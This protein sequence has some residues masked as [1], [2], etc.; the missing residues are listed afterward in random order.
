MKK[1]LL[2]VS[3]LFLGI[4]LTSCD[5]FSPAETTT[6]TEELTADTE[7][8]IEISTASELEAIDM[9]KSY[10]LMADLNLLGIEW[11]PL[12]TYDIPYLGNFDGNNHTISNV[13][14]TSDQSV[15][16]GLF[17]RVSGN[18][19]DL[20]LTNVSIIFETDFLTYVGGL[21]GFTE[22]N[23]ENVTVTGVIDVNNTLSNSYVGLLIGLSQA[24]IDALTTVIDFKPNTI[25][26]N[27]VSG[28]ITL[29]SD[30]V[31][32][33]G[34][35]IGKTFNSNV[36]NNYSETVITV[37]LDEYLGYIGGF[38]GDNYG[39]LLYGYEDDIDDVNIYIENNVSISDITV[40]ID[41]KDVSVGGFIGNNHS[42]FNR[43]NY[44]E[45]EIHILGN[46]EATT[47]LNIGGY[48][49]ENWIS[50]VNNTVTV[51]NLTISIDSDYIN[52]NALFIIG[53]DFS[54]A[55]FQHN[56]VACLSDD[57]DVSDLAGLSEIT[58]ADYESST[59]FSDTMLWETEQINKI[60]N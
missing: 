36:A 46:V 4:S 53:G 3:V 48:I 41:K 40:T 45:S 51:Y 49:G 21:A 20:T 35:M 34:G 43:D 8:Y 6:T 47:T 57:I 28:T 14:I 60:L 18:I 2:F 39:G 33:I 50:Q 5:I 32:F 17:G 38:I 44:C 12:G 30:N 29:D 58:S 10:I 52:N 7:N 15:Y 55:D 22:G 24:P 26:N 54:E 13:T 27:S 37:R 1:I 59:F 56:Y 31:P 23:V 42:G 19:Q 11:I 25:L 9:T 16:N